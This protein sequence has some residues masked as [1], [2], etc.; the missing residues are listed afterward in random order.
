VWHQVE[1]R[2]PLAFQEF[3]EP[4][5]LFERVGGKELIVEQLQS[6]A[7]GR[8]AVR[9]PF[10][11][12]RTRRPATPAATSTDLRQQILADF[13]ALR[14]PLRTEQLDARSPHRSTA[15]VTNIDFEAW[16]D[17]LGDPPLAMAFLDQIVDGAII[18]K[19]NGRSYRAHRARPTPLGPGDQA[20][21]RSR[22]GKAR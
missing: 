4:G 7:P 17:Y 12:T 3:F 21:G 5:G 16:A 6:L 13:Q 11:Q 22:N 20:G 19:I 18:V 2:D 8:V 10:I 1:A 15:L 9:G 14:V